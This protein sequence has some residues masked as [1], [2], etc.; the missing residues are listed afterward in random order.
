MSFRLPTG[1]GEKCKPNERVMRDRVPRS[2]DQ[3]RSRDHQFFQEPVVEPSLLDLAP[4]SRRIEDK[5]I[6]VLHFSLHQL[7]AVRHDPAEIVPESSP[8]Q[9]P[10]HHTRMGIGIELAALKRANA[11]PGTLLRGGLSVVSG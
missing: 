11:G 10:H 9:F 2:V 7:R 4:E 3:R 8:S 1:S 6:A 5:G